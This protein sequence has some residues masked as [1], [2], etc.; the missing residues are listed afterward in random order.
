MTGGTHYEIFFKKHA[1]ASWALHEA[2]NDRDT[3]IRAAH[4]LVRSVDG[5][6]VRVTKEKFD[7]Q[8]RVFKSVPVW[9]S[10]AETMGDV[11][12]KTGESKLPCLTPDDLS[13]PHARD[14]IF[15]VLQ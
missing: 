11:K 15:R 10:G 1:K 3:A 14:T 9:E 13:L 5:S 4:K 12:E 6:S 7:E 8:H 2:K